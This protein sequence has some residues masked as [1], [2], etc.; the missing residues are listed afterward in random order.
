V[1]FL[2]RKKYLLFRIKKNE[3]YAMKEEFICFVFQSSLEEQ[4]FVRGF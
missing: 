2:D 1:F 3:F 4:L